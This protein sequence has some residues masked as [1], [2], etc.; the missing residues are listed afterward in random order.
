MSA[1]FEG[2]TSET[3]KGF[4]TLFAGLCK[5]CGLCIQK[6]PKE[7]MSWSDMLGVYGTPAVKITDE[8][9]ACGLCETNCPDCAIAVEKKKKSKN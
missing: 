2:H 4:W 8:C 5:G 9:T 3:E 6:C 1:T 7:C